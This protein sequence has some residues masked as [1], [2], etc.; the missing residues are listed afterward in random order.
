M[1]N[2]QF[3][4]TFLNAIFIT[5]TE[6]SRFIVDDVWQTYG[7]RRRP[8]D[9]RLMGNAMRRAVLAGYIEPTNEYVPSRQ[10]QCHGNPR[11]VWRSKV[12]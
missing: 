7:E 11:R 8:I 10:P 6:K 12:R 3:V 2:E 9:N 1:S 5:A 4:D